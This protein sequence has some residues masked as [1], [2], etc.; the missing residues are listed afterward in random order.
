VTFALVTSLKKEIGIND[1]DIE[2]NV[3]KAVVFISLSDKL[4]FESGSYIVLSEVKEIL[5]KVA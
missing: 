2:V 1:P 3:D 5:G 4:L